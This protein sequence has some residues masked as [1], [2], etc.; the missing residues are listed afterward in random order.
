MYNAD[1]PSLIVYS[2]GLR[3]LSGTSLP[4]YL[5]KVLAS[6]QELRRCY[7]KTGILL[8]LMGASFDEL[9]SKQR[10]SQFQESI[11]AH[12]LA[13]LQTLQGSDFPVLRIN[14]IQPYSS[15]ENATFDGIHFL[16]GSGVNEALVQV[17]LNRLC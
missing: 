10:V 14:E 7:P 16:E 3:A 11:T 9:R 17:L 15:N 4:I 1:D 2:M 13:V 5:A 6:L 8:Q 12:N